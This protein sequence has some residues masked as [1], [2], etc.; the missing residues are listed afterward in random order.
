MKSFKEWKE[1]N[2]ELFEKTALPVTAEDENPNDEDWYYYKSKIQGR[3]GNLLNWFVDEVG[4]KKLTLVRKGFIVQE[5]LDALDMNVSQLV[6]VIGN[7]K[8][9]IYQ[10]QRDAANT[11]MPMTTPSAPAS[12]TTAPTAATGSRVG[13]KSGP[14][15]IA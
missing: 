9:S 14:T 6:R 4:K 5:V 11:A 3:A 7:I 13:A 8:K 15:A 10:H 12:P 2:S 1:E